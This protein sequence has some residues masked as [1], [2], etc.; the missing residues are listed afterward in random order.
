[1]MGIV[2][3]DGNGMRMRGITGDLCVMDTVW[4]FYLVHCYAALQPL[5]PHVSLVP[6]SAL[7]DNLLC[8]HRA[9]Q[10]LKH[11]STLYPVP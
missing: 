10:I 7:K 5:S 3:L 8:K 1:M 6:G 11:R 4:E 2:G 9:K